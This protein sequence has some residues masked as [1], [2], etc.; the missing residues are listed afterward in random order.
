[1]ERSLNTYIHLAN[2]FLEVVE[3]EGVSLVPSD[4]VIVLILVVAADKVGFVA[5]G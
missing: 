1:M 3:V 2:I 5:L 4:V